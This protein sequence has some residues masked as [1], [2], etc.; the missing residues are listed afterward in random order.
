M[1]REAGG[2]LAEV[3]GLH[4]GEWD[5]KFVV[6]GQWM[7]DP[8]NVDRRP[9]GSGGENAILTAGVGRGSVLHFGFHSP[10]LSSGRGYVVY[11]PPGYF[12]SGDR[13]PVLTLLHGALDWE[14][15]WVHTGGVHRA[16]DRLLGE[17]RV[18][19]MIVVMPRDN[20]ELFNGDGRVVDY[21]A[22]DLVGHVDAEFRTVARGS[23]RGLD[24]LS[25]GGFTSMVVGAARPDL[26]GSVGSMSGSYDGRVFE[27][28]ERQAGAMRAHRQRYHLSSGYDEP[29]LQA[30][31]DLAGALRRLGVEVEHH[32]R[33]GW[34]DW[35]LWAPSAESNLQFHAWSFQ[36]G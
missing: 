29:C 14:Y 21:L 4:H 11:L 17:G 35:S 30:C 28:V 19:P 22:R 31:R 6:D 13:Y 9:D 26:F 23:H 33:P 10:A 5:Y 18:G 12:T 36:R 3:D 32:E 1:R 27:A 7:P 15:T 16:L 24:G 34:H 8:Q 20:G 2:F 25:T